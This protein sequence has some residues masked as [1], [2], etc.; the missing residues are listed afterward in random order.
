MPR[1]GGFN[2]K[3]L[4]ASAVI[5]SP[6]IRQVITWIGGIDASKEVA[7]AALKSGWTIGI[8]SGGI[9]EIFETN[10]DNETIILRRRKGIVRLAF[11]TGTPLVPCYVF[12]NSVVFSLWY[13][14][15]NILNTISRALK[16]SVFYF[17]GRWSLPIPCKNALHLLPQHD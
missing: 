5:N 6:I 3:G 2:F 10:N 9:A 13:D 4:T 15:W 11:R 8:P 14:P 7:G 1:T 16:F 17:W 12:G